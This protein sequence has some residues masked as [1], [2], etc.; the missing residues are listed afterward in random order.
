[1]RNKPPDLPCLS[2]PCHHHRAPSHGYWH[3]MLKPVM[4]WKTVKQILVCIA[5]VKSFY[6]DTMKQSMILL[7]GKSVR[8]SVHHTHSDIGQDSEL[9]AT[10]YKDGRKVTKPE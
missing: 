10:P 7:H 8:L 2:D 1:M 4:H 6:N 9:P 3:Q 5:Y